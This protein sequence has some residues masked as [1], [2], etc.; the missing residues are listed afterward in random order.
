[1]LT[2]AQQG[3]AFIVISLNRRSLRGKENEM[4]QDQKIY[5]SLG[6]GEDK[7]CKLVSGD[8]CP[9]LDPHP[10]PTHACNLSP[11]MSGGNA[12]P[13]GRNWGY[14]F[15]VLSRCCGR[16]CDIFLPGALYLYCGA[17]N[18]RLTFCP[19]AP[20]KILLFWGTTVSI[21]N[22][23]R[24]VGR[25]SFPHE[26][27]SFSLGIDHLYAARNRTHLPAP[28]PQT[29]QKLRNKGLRAQI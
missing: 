9:W 4:N 20:W 2:K 10:L 8:L 26:I 3:K 22:G 28:L 17:P 14:G 15:R 6:K 13:E 11:F 27:W 29:K 16:D 24:L 7:Y 19:A 21:L 5:N 12:F 18:C 1:M 23:W 25:P